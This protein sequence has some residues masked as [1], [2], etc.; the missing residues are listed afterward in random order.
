MNT[1]PLW[2]T[3]YKS[4]PEYLPLLP[5]H[6]Y[7]SDQL[8]QDEI[9]AS[10]NL[11]L[12]GPR[13]FPHMLL[14]E[15][16]IARKMNTTYPI[17]KR[18]PMWNGMTYI[19]TDYYF[20]M[21]MAHPEFPKNIQE[22]IEFLLSIVRNKCIYLDRH[23]V[24]LKNL[25]VLHRNNSQAFR[26]ILERFS[27]NVL[28]I[29]TTHHINQL[30]APLLS[31][32]ICQRVPLPTE[33]QQ[34]AVLHKLTNKK[35]IRYH[36][37]NLVQN[38]FF[39]EA[40]VIKQIKVLPTLSYPPLQDFIDRPYEKEDIRKLSYKLFQ[41]GISISTI[42]LDLLP[43]LSEEQGHMFIQKAAEIEHMS[44]ITDSSKESFFIEHLLNIYYSYKYKL[45]T[46]VS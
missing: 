17:S 5:Y 1:F 30:E 15:H 36:E 21:D 28:F 35:T 31:R 12:Y 26:V 20:E 33:E 22:M 9:N 7:I 27:G 3:F 43:T 32:M 16:A 18:T 45:N 42:T 25:D 44:C 2:D 11:L 37:R 39:N 4:F 19:E 40:A 14:I 29:A 6:S 38:I 34:K 23:I 46:P 8:L 41:Q 13:G 10:P 24:I